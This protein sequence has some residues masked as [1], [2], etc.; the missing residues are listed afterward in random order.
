MPSSGV[1]S[2]CVELPRCQPRKDQVLD[3]TENT[4]SGYS[5]RATKLTSLVVNTISG[6]PPN[7]Q[8]YWPCD[9]IS[10]N[11]S[12]LKMLTIGFEQHTIREYEATYGLHRFNTLGRQ[13][14]KTS[15]ATIKN[16]MSCLKRQRRKSRRTIASS[17]ESLRLTSFDLDPMLLHGM[18]SFIDFDKL[19]SLRLESCVNLHNGLA[20]LNT[21]TR[22]SCLRSLTVRTEFGNDV[23]WSSLEAFICSLIGLTD[24]CLLV[25]GGFEDLDLEDILKRHGRTLRSLVVDT[26]TG[27]RLSAT[28][29]TSVQ[30]EKYGTRSYITDISVHCPNLIELGI[31]LDWQ[32]V[33]ILGSLQED[34]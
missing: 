2:D 12:T 27:P 19:V 3:L 4:D 6:E 22:L 18:G 16:L 13:I 17:I 32:A 7:L 24:L 23:M 5:E 1:L 8:N 11:I 29:T 34:V 14:S 25:E 10:S 20:R 15:E 26:R 31:T 30:P 21:T 28:E 33:T 9:M